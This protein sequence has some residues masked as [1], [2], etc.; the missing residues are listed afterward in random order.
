M[1]MS[2]ILEKKQ[3]IRLRLFTFISMTSAKSEI[4]KF[5]ALNFV[6]LGENKKL[7]DENLE[8]QES[9]KRMKLGYSLT[10]RFLTSA[11][12]EL[13]GRGACLDLFDEIVDCICD[14]E[15][16]EEFFLTLSLIEC[17]HDQ[18]TSYV[19]YVI[20]KSTVKDIIPNYEKLRKLVGP[21]FYGEVLGCLED[22]IKDDS[23]SEREVAGATV[24]KNY[25]KK[26]ATK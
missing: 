12:E 7:E 17:C 5:A 19:T 18:V 14:S 13:S 8:L 4:N 25:I 10:K 21:V 2:L 1:K 23:Y 11:I 6:L 9:L 3:V 26:Q 15:T 22:I 20:H 16:L 24:L